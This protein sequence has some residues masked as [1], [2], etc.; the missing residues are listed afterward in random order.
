MSLDDQSSGSSE[1]G[2]YT[3]PV[4]TLKEEGDKA[5]AQRKQQSLVR[6]P[7]TRDGLWISKQMRDAEAKRVRMET[8]DFYNEHRLTA[9]ALGKVNSDDISLDDNERHILIE[10]NAKR[11]DKIC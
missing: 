7:H 8:R 10:K 4:S 6:S 3:I 1:E 2:E 9:I 11:D 5:T